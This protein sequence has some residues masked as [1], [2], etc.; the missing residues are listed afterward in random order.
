MTSPAI[1]AHGTEAELLSLALLMGIAIVVHGCKACEW[2]ALEKATPRYLPRKEVYCVGAF[3]G[4]RH[5]LE[6]FFP[7]RDPLATVHIMHIGDKAVNPLSPARN[8]GH[9]EFLTWVGQPVVPAAIR[10][11]ILETLYTRGGPPPPSIWHDLLPSKPTTSLS[12]TRALQDA[13]S[14]ADLPPAANTRCQSKKFPLKVNDCLDKYDLISQCFSH[15]HTTLT[16]PEGERLE[17]SPREQTSACE[18]APCRP[19]IT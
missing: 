6:K 7:K 5:N 13:K 17:A 11:Q 15:H 4:E 8:V 10:R 9:F 2:G 19:T 3:P 18:Q 14:R 16:C 1:S 12:P